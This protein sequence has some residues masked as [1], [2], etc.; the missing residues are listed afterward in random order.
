MNN[1]EFLR[2]ICPNHT[3]KSK[4]N[5]SELLTILEN[6]QALQLQQP[7]DDFNDEPY[8]LPL[9]FIQTI[10]NESDEAEGFLSN[11]R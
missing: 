3:E 8:I 2:D 11:N 7:E 1:E 9:E 4:W 6:Y 10:K 5:K